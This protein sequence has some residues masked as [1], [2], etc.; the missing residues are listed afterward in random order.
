MAVPSRSRPTCQARQLSFREMP[1]PSPPPRVPLAAATTAMLRP[2]R[3][4]L[5]LLSL[6]EQPLELQI[7]G[8]TLLHAALVGLSAGIMGCAFF[9]SLEWIQQLVLEGLA[10]YEPLRASGE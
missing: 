10:G 4:L 1:E 8:R 7:A 3:G 9:A 5:A 6:R 2:V